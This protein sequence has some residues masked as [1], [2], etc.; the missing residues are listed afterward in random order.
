[1]Q[2]GNGCRVGGLRVDGVE[3]LRQG[4]RF[5]CFPM[6]PWC[7]RTRDGRFR[8]GGTV[9]QLPLNSPPHAIHGTVRDAAWRTARASDDEAVFTYDLA[10]PWPYAGPRHPDLRADRGLADAHPGRRDVR[11]LLP[12]AGRL[13]P[14]VPPEPRRGERGRAGRLH[15]RLAGGARRRPPAHRPRGSTRSPAPGTTASGCPTASTSPSPGR[16][17][18]ELKVDQPRASGSSSTTSR[19]TPSAWSR[20]PARPNGLNTRPRLVT[21]IEPLETPRPGRWRGEPSD[22]PVVGGSL[23]LQALT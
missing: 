11:R 16:E 8:N 20:R 18:L 19:T 14:L 22:G 1:M 21:P 9:H 3:L 10:E 12:G 23:E 5:G 7:G 15:A 6:V 17:Q 4:E 13:A 2:P